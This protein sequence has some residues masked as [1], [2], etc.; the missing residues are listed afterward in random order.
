MVDRRPQLKGEA[1][2]GIDGALPP[3]AAA[4]R[5]ATTTAGSADCIAV[6]LDI[7]AKWWERAVFYEI[8]VRSFADGDGDGIGDLQGVRDRL[9]Y[10]AE[11]GVDALWLTPFYR[12]PMADGGY[13][14][15]D[16]FAVDPLF[17]DLATFDALVHEAHALDLKVTIDVVPNHTSDRHRDFEA[18]LYDRPG[19]PARERYMFRPGNADGGPPNNWR[20]V[21]GGAAWTRELRH[22]EWYLHLFAPEQP[23]LNW[24]NP[25][26]GDEYERIL[27]FWLDRGVD[28]F[29][30]DVA[31]GLVKD[32]ALRDNPGTEREGAFGVGAEERFAY[33]QPEV[34]D[35]YRRW[36]GIL[37]SYDSDRVATGEVWLRDAEALARYVRPDE[38]DLAFNFRY[39]SAAWNA[40]AIRA[41][42]DTEFE[43]LPAGTPATWVLS[44][45]DVVRH[46]TRFGSL[47]RA[48]AATLLMLA[49]PG[50]CYLYT[51]EELGLPEAD[52]PVAAIQDPQWFRSGGTHPSRDGAR[53]PI[54]WSGDRPPYGFS[55][56]GVATWL[57]QPGDWAGLTAAAQDGRPE[58]TLELYRSA[59]ALR[60]SDPALAGDDFR[61]LPSPEGVLRL[62]RT[63]GA[64]RLECWVN[65]TSDPVL[66]P[67]GDVLVRSSPA[68]EGGGLAPDGGVWLRPS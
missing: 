21:F 5:V 35:I 11:L 31:H 45:H 56:E 6:T 3:A 12:S 9:P 61:W 37:D 57:P 39:L 54:P 28:G 13:D 53:V 58:S 51:G 24:R 22:G 65:V 42:I 7:V 26:V 49:L 44:N 64:A 40:D 30:I 20:S 67:A 10:L 52:V 27:R 25:A 23:D 32:A 16:P 4:L 48:R 59:L 41:T 8:Y 50:V 68:P 43:V 2:L 15:A 36:R 38:L 46:R 47:E 60:R 33:D 62:E 17:G 29:R 63:A 55:P 18:A 66:L 19:S 14:V 1:H 34:H